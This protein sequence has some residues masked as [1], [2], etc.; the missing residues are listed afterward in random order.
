M[1]KYPEALKDY[2]KAL[3]INPKNHWALFNKGNLQYFYLDKKLRGKESIRKA[4]QLGN[5]NAKKVLKNLK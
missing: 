1:K 2:E 4:A 5:T 3:I